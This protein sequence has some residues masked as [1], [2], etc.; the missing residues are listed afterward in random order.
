MP[1]NSL[2]LA[3]MALALVLLG[4]APDQARAGDPVPIAWTAPD[5]D[6]LP[7]DAWGRTVRL[8]RDLIAHTYA[9]IGPEVADPARRYAGNNLA[10]QNCHLGAGTHPFGDPLVGSFANYPNYRARSGAVG[11]IQ[12]RIQG[13]MLRSLNGRELP[14]D[15]PDMTAMVAYLKFLASGRPV[16]EPVPGQGSGRMPELDRAADPVRGRAV[17]AQLCAACHG[18]HGEGQRNGTAGDA[19]GYA[20]PPLW[21]SDSFNDGAG[22][23]RLIEAANFIRN[24]MPVGTTWQHPVVSAPD[25]WDVAAYMQSE[26]RPH[27]AGL[28][29]DYPNRLEKPVDTPY[30]PYADDFSEEQHRLGPFEPIRAAIA[31]LK[32]QRAAK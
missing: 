7:D 25:A 28:E 4:P 20:V 19:K 14:P 8:G 21:G 27:M 10:C 13:C 11:T 23:N 18:D 6:K 31:A 17:Y 5:P 12:E 30:E 22:M 16:G 15:G 26:P 3:A 29:R 32:A 2:S 9:H 24:N 1:P